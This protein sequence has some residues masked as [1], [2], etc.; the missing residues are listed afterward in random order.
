[1]KTG[2]WFQ[3][4]TGKRFYVTD[5]DPDDVDIRD[6]AHALSMICRF[7][8]H[9]REFY[10]VAQ[11]SVLCSWIVEDWAREKGKDDAYL[12]LCTLLHDASEAYLGDVVRPLKMG[13]L[14]YCDLESKMMRVIY[15]GLGIEYPTEAEYK[16]I[17]K[18]DDIML[19]SERRDLINH[20]NIS[21]GNNLSGVTPV[22]SKILPWSFDIAESVFL[23]EY[24]NLVAQLSVTHDNLVT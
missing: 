20:K 13:L 11:H 1:M 9:T 16:I 24:N 3:T 23:N 12:R 2:E 6:I 18:V 17:K 10:S 14:D 22:E 4:F 19:V 5:P 7:G 21:W 15:S 8:G